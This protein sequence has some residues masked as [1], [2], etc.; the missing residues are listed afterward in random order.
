MHLRPGVHQTCSFFYVDFIDKYLKSLGCKSFHCCHSCFFFIS[1]LPAFFF[2]ANFYRNFHSIVA[3]HQSLR[4]QLVGLVSFA[5]F[6]QSQSSQ[7]E[8]KENVFRSLT[9]LF[10][11]SEE[12]TLFFAVN[13]GYPETTG[14]VYII[15]VIS[16]I[17][18]CS[19]A[20]PKLD[21]HD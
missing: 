18:Y 5:I 8:R 3:A 4:D 17:V 14:L 7:V 11:R 16:A 21:L 12:N 20:V 19:V 10:S 6:L 2:V 13:F 9:S 15:N 1:Q